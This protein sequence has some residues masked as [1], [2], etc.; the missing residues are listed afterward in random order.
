MELSRRSIRIILKLLEAE[1]AITTMELA[2]IFNVSVR[3]IKYDL[4]NIREWLKTKNIKLYSQRN[5]GTWFDLTD[6]EKM[7]LKNELLVTQS[8]DVYPDQSTRV[9]RIAMQLLMTNEILTTDK[10]ANFLSVSKN[11]IVADLEKVDGLVENFQVE[12][13]RSSGYGLFI[14]GKE[15]DIRYLI[16]HLLQ[17]NFTEYDIYNIMNQLVNPN[18][19]RISS[20]NLGKDDL[21]QSTYT[22][23]I[24]ELSLLLNPTLLDQFN[25]TELLSISL[26]TAISVCRLRLKQPISSLKLLSNQEELT[27]KND[28]PF[29]IMEKIFEKYDLPLLEEEYKY[30]A[31]NYTKKEP[32]QD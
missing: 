31:S 14:Q 16:E 12:L 15:E 17:T 18:D 22:Q 20:I 11:T 21:F 1:S 3:T 32:I 25:Y 28:I 13:N 26:R 8:F 27:K 10:L 24:E 4:A 7:T 2:E 19:E 9:I 23:V 30:I 29:L 5:K 6:V